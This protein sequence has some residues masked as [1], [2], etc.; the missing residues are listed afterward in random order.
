ML[1]EFYQYANNNHSV[2]CMFCWKISSRQ[3]SSEKKQFKVL[4]NSKESVRREVP[5]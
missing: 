3:R 5:R 1:Q 2:S 4:E